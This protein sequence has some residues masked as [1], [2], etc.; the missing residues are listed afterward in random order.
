[1]ALWDKLGGG[2]NVEDRRGTNSLGIGGGLITAV[3]VLGLGYFG[4]NVDPALISQLISASGVTSSE[5]SNEFK[6]NDSYES[7][8]R[9]VI[10]STNAYWSTKLGGQTPYKG[11]RL[12]LFRDATQS[13][14]GIATSD[15][16]PHYCPNDAT[17]YLDET[18]FD[19]LQ[20]QYGGSSGD[21]A[22]AYVLAHEV[23]HHVQNS[24]GT[25]QQVQSDPSYQ[26]TGENSLSV[27]L[28]LQ[29]DCYAGA[30]AHSL[31]DKGVFESPAE[32]QEAIDAA[33]AVGDDRIQSTSGSVN[34]ETWT[35]GSSEQRVASFNKGW[36]SD[37]YTVCKL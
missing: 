20:K 9:N 15:V 24:T 21:V 36:N 2:G 10:G 16:G 19:V 6:G 5:Q 33:S 14:C 7:F 12:V 13:A 23:G 1:M 32:I 22:Q 29:A 11:P 8:A 27:R 26:A 28:E 30:W 4:I 18:F 34:P 3:V 37:D 35:H 31:R 25:M 17:I